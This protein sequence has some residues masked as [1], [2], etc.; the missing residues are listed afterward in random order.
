[1]FLCSYVNLLCGETK[2]GCSVSN[3]CNGV[4]E[5]CA[6]TSSCECESGFSRNGNGTCIV[7][8]QCNKIASIL[9]VNDS[10]EHTCMLYIVKY[11][12]IYV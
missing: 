3:E 12:Y 1:M 5:I 6:T 4:N 11:I 8:G 2:L 10:V 9:I 7:E